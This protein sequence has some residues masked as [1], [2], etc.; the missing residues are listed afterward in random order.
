MGDQVLALQV[1]QRVL[2]LH[3]LCISYLAIEHRGEIDPELAARMGDHLF[4]CDLCQEACPWN[5]KAPDTTVSDFRPRE[6]SYRPELEP[7][8]DLNRE[9]LLER[10]AGTA[11]MRAGLA[12]LRRNARIVERNQC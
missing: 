5:R 8:L 3:Q 10:F 7:L 12:G 9:S 11:L 6:A 2:Q 4:G 1:P